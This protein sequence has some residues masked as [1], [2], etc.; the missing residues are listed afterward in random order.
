V[1]LR[2][3]VNGTVDSGLAASTER[4]GD[5]LVVTVEP[6]DPV[7]LDG[8]TFA[9]FTFAIPDYTG[10]GTYDL[11]TEDRPGL[12]YELYLDGAEEGYFWA[13]EYGPGIVTVSDG[14]TTME[15]RFA[16]RD[17]GSN[18]IDLEGTIKLR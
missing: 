15:A 11:G 10:P 1:T 16:F 13:R 12:L 6:V 8:G 18:Q 17:P 9:G 5:Q 3:R 7:S 14:G 2:G 4:D